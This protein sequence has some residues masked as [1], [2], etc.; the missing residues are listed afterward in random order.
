VTYYEVAGETGQPQVRADLLARLAVARVAT[1][2]REAEAVVVAKKKWNELSSRTRQM[3]IVG[4]V[5]EGVLKIAALIDL[6]RRPSSEVRGS[7]VR[8]ALGV[9]LINSV[10]AVPVAYF[11]FGRRRSS[12]VVTTGFE[13]R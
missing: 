6:A 3:I 5:F 12:N 1:R 10:G 9:T 7:K 4:G 2:R 8:W 11:A 13:A